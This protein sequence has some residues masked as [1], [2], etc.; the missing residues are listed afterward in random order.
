MCSSFNY[1]Y[2][3]DLEIQANINQHVCIIRVNDKVFYKYLHFVLISII[4]QFQIDLL[5]LQ[6]L[7][8][9]IYNMYQAFALI[10]KGSLAYRGSELVV[11]YQPLP[12]TIE[13][14]KVQQ[15]SSTNKG[16]DEGTVKSN[17]KDDE[18]TKRR[19]FNNT[20]FIQRRKEQ[21]E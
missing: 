10:H 1:S 16:G 6:L 3:F 21:C 8:P 5:G 7:W 11:H 19:N 18:S 20:D 13:R 2:Y 4:G 14:R 17:N 12:T 15:E 9:T